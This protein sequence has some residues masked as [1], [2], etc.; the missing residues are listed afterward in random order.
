VHGWRCRGLPLAKWRESCLTSSTRAPDPACLSLALH[1]KLFR[2]THHQRRHGRG[3][4]Q[5]LSGCAS[6]YRESARMPSNTTSPQSRLTSCR[7][8]T[9]FCLAQSRS[10][11]TLRS[12]QYAPHSS[13]T[14]LTPPRLLFDF[15][16]KQNAKKANCVHATYLVTGKKR[17]DSDSGK[18]KGADG[19]NGKNGEDVNMRNSPFM[20]SMPE[21]EEDDESDEEPVKQTTILLVREEELEGGIL[22]ERGQVAAPLT[23]RRRARRF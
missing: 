21:P 6:A 9:G 18:G 4:L 20:S 14:D 2:S 13:T 7:L 10:M 19:V 22:H 11:S 3:K 5:R 8:H 23:S 12:G 16:Q 15:H 17:T 1:S